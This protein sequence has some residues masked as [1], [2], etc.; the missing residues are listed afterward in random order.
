MINVYRLRYWVWIC[1]VWVCGSVFSQEPTALFIQKALDEP[2]KI[3]FRNKTLEEVFAQVGKDL[4]I[5]LQ[6]EM[7]A[8]DQLPYGQ[9]TQLESVE[10]EGMAWRDALRELL[11][12]LALTYQVGQDRI[13]ILG[14]PELM[15]QPRRMNL[16]ELSALVTIQNTRL[17]DSEDKLLKQIREVSKTNFNL[18]EFGRQVDKAEKDIAEDILTKSPEPAPKVL[19]AYSRQR[20]R[21]QRILDATWYVRAEVEYGR[22]EA[23]HIVILPAQQLLLM[24]LDRRITVSYRNQ[25]AQVILLDLARQANVE[26]RFEPGCLGFLEPR[27]R[28]STSLEMQEAT[29]KRAFE[30]L[31]GITGL[32]YELKP[33]HV[34]ITVG[35]NLKDMAKMQR[36]AEGSGTNPAMSVIITK[37]PGTDLETMVFVRKEDLEEMGLLEKFH[38]YYLSSVKTYFNFLEDFEPPK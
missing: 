7:S 19:D 1:L 30:A 26:I 2:A 35:E 5:A 36:V 27:V 25:P 14:T 29:I 17:N 24:K 22:A 13:Y 34:R 9:L 20:G 3:H 15:R 4:G 18:I 6:P 21:Q 31:V 32:E 23:I 12:P 33:D 16:V 11:K 28:N 10:L 38:Q 8:L 37:I